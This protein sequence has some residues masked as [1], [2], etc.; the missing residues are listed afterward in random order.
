MDSNR[1]AGLRFG[2]RPGIG[3]DG[4]HAFT[5]TTDCAM[6]AKG[7]WFIWRRRNFFVG[8]THHGDPPP[9]SSRK[10]KP[11]AVPQREISRRDWARNKFDCPRSLH[12]WSLTR[13]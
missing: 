3:E 7:K 8:R 6:E 13:G 5:P 9:R 10:M 1:L 4:G 12:S 11:F 2:P